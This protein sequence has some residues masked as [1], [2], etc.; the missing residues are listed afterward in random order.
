M[1]VCHHTMKGEPR[2]IRV[3]GKVMFQM[4]IKIKKL[5]MWE[6]VHKKRGGGTEVE[7]SLIALSVVE[8]E[9]LCRFS[10]R[11]L[12]KVSILEYSILCQLKITTWWPKRSFSKKNL[13]NASNFLSIFGSI[14]FDTESITVS[15]FCIFFLF[16]HRNACRYIGHFLEFFQCFCILPCLLSKWERVNVGRVSGPGF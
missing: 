13:R 11:K 12:S 10:N 1:I 7:E 15:V 4:N 14:N 3:S 16:W 8:K 9:D 5:W 6:N 2:V